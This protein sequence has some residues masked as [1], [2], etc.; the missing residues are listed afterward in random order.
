MA[1]KVEEELRAIKAAEKARD[2]NRRKADS[3][4]LAG[5]VGREL[6]IYQKFATSFGKVLVWL[7]WN[8]GNPVINKVTVPLFLFLFKWF[9]N[10]WNW[11]AF[12]KDEFGNRKLSYAR[13]SLFIVSWLFLGAL[14]ASGFVYDTLVYLPTHT[15]DRV[16]WLSSA[17]EI[18]P[19]SNIF[20]VQGCDKL[21]S[22]VCHEDQALY[23]RVQASWFNETWS[24]LS[25]RGLFFPDKVVAT[26]GSDWSR[27]T[28]SDFGSRWRF[29]IF[30]G[31]YYPNLLVTSCER[32]SAT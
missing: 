27:C 13:G 32:S 6:S 1:N 17:Q 22:K 21:V 26:I 15:K 9:I 8:F 12:K 4:T 31:N 7:W 20:S 14:I 18:Y 2:F 5:A 30:F 3:Q 23:Y 10:L 11:V 24:I 19:D 29:W 25:G 28:V 16:V